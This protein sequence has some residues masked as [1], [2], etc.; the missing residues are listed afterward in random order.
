MSNLVKN[1]KGQKVNP[2]LVVFWSIISAITIGLVVTLI[3]LFIQNLSL[4]DKD[5]ITYLSGNEIFQQEDNKYY[6]LVYDFNSSE[7][8]LDELEEFVLNYQTFL[9]KYY[10]KDV[11]DAVT[12]L[13][14]YGVDTALPINKKIII[15]NGTENIEGATAV[16]NSLSNDSSKLLRID[17]ENLPVLL[18]IENGTVS[19]YVDTQNGIKNYLQEIIY[20]YTK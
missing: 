4:N 13:K 11:N 2:K 7:D 3:V 14:L 10:G 8:D 17:D 18:V 12:A 19:D 9:K 6:V 15:E 5:D 16:T 20:S 1:K